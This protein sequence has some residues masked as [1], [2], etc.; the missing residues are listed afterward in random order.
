MGLLCSFLRP[1]HLPGP[2]SL[3]A[4]RRCSCTQKSERGPLSNH[5]SYLGTRT[6]LL[7]PTTCP[8]RQFPFFLVSPPSWTVS[9]AERK[10]IQGAISTSRQGLVGNKLGEVQWVV[11]QT[12]PPTPGTQKAVACEAEDATRSGLTQHS[13]RRYPSPT[14]AKPPLLPLS[15]N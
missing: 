1:N 9:L 12:T 5:T 14:C 6:L 4:L 11:Q 13:S 2:F 8:A 7:P 3:P 15:S 10:G